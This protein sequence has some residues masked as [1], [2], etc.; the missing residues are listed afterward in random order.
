MS[1]LSLCTI[2]GQCNF[3]FK[4]EIHPPL[5]V[6]QDLGAKVPTNLQPVATLEDSFSFQN[7]KSV[8]ETH[9]GV[10]VAELLNKMGA[11]GRGMENIFILELHD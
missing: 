10:H 4:A 9:V 11:Q 2:I 8:G 3:S 7:F 1:S 6:A 5:A